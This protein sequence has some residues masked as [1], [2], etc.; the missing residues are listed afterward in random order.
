MKEPQWP[1]QERQTAPEAEASE[2]HGKAASGCGGELGQRVLR[3][4]QRVG[5][6]DAYGFLVPG[7]LPGA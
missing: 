3:R 1:C 6:L 5:A 7:F 4:D 2:R